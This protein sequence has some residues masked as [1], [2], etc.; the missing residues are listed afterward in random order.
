MNG[1]LHPLIE[2]ACSEPPW[3]PAPADATSPP[4][5]PF[6]TLLRPPVIGSGLCKAPHIAVT[7]YRASAGLSV[8]SGWQRGVR[9][10]HRKGTD[11]LDL[12]PPV[13]VVERLWA[14]E[15]VKVSPIQGAVRGAHARAAHARAAH[16]PCQRVGPATTSWSSDVPE[17]RGRKLT[18]VG[19]S[20]RPRHMEPGRWTNVE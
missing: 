5:S 14:E 8:A 4:L 10:G 1:A 16:A 15:A 11:G 2:N 20:S 7:P 3:A 13:L 19:R 17:V 6:A 9:P 12:G 18:F